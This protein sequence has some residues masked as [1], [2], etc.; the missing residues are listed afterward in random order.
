M[1]KKLYM[2][3]SS[4]KYELP[5][6]IADSPDELSKMTGFKPSYIKTAISKYLSGDKPNLQFR[7]IEYEESEGKE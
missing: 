1:L 4:D 6:A 7:R 3:V 5:L 2:M